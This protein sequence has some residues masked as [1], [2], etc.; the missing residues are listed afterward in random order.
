MNTNELNLGNNNNNSHNNQ[1]YCVLILIKMCQRFR[2]IEQSSFRLF[3]EVILKIN[4]GESI[5]H[6]F[7]G[8]FIIWVT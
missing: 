8:V 3:G 7:K 1:K 6:S 2:M 4:L 5:L